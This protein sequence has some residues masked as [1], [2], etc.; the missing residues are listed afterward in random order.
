VLAEG[1]AQHGAHVFVGVGDQGALGLGDGV[2]LVEH[3]LDLG[4]LD[5]LE[6]GDGLAQRLHFLGRQMLEDLA[7]LFLAQRHQQDCGVLYA[8]V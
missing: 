6:L 1:L 8:L 5:D 7:G 3:G 2:E 4:A